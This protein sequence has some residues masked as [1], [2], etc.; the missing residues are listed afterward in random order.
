MRKINLNAIIQSQNKDDVPNKL[1]WIYE[2]VRDVIV[3]E[4]EYGE[5]LSS[6]IKGN[7]ESDIALLMLP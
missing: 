4:P 7:Q 1:L 6:S 2:E 3:S 5:L